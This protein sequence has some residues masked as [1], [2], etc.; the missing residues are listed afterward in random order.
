MPGT[1]TSRGLTTLATSDVITSFATTINSVTTSVNTALVNTLQF[2]NYTAANAAARNAITGMVDGSLCFQTDTNELWYYD[3]G[4][5]TWRILQR[6]KTAYTYALGGVGGT[7]AQSQ[8]G[9]YAISGGICYVEVDY[10]ITNTTNAFVSTAT[11]TSASGNGTTVTYTLAAH[12][13]VPGQQVSI[14]GFTSTQYNLTNVTIVT[15]TSTTFTV[16]NGATGAS[17]GSGTVTSNYPIFTLPIAYAN[18]ANA[19]RV[20]M[21]GECSFLNVSTGASHLGTSMWMSATTVTPMFVG[22]NGLLN[23]PRTTTGNPLTEAWA[24]GDRI[25]LSFAYPV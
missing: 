9:F 4:T 13:F 24:V 18:Y 3:T 6:P 12:P 15:T 10:A 8:S 20:Q 17:S 7:T 5:T 23:P 11:A 14:T 21:A 25:Q 16:A 1:P 19:P 22:T 2:Y